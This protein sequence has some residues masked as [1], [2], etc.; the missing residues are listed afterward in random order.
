MSA[1]APLSA[2]RLDEIASRAADL[3]EYSVSHGGEVDALAGE[4][5]PALLGEV[6]RLRAELTARP[7][8]AERL[9]DAADVL[10]VVC[11]SLEVHVDGWGDV[12]RRTT[13][14]VCAVLYAAADAAEVTAEQR[15][16]AEG[17]GGRG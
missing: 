7:S 12:D 14:S 15:A 10:D 11:E 13:E 2:R 5:V 1:G 3:C 6:F 8:R 9:R 4:D 17:G 16:T